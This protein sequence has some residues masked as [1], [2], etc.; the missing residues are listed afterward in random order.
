MSKLDEM[1]ELED[2]NPVEQPAEKPFDAEEF[3]NSGTED[4]RAGY[5]N[6]V[7]EIAEE[8]GIKA[9]GIIESDAYAERKARNF[10]SRSRVEKTANSDLV[11][12]DIDYDTRLL[13]GNI[14]GKNYEI[15]VSYRTGR[16]S[17]GSLRIID[18]KVDGE[19]LDHREAEEIFA[20]YARIAEDR[21]NGIRMEQLTKETNNENNE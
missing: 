3:L 14:D 8:K 2:K 4:R 1:S 15:K 17:D 10:G 9:E 16:G 19:P 12:K 7:Q 11:L 13:E 20:D 18:S 6:R 21:S 5:E